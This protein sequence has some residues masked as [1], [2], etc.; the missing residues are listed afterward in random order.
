MKKFYPTILLALLCLTTK[1]QSPNWAWAQGVGNTDS[2]YGVSIVNDALGNLYVTGYFASSSILFGS[3]LLTNSGSSDI[4]IAKYD[5]LGN[6]LWAKSAGGS[7]TEYAE[8]VATD[9]FGNVYVSGNFDSPTINFGANTLTN[10]GNTDMFI[11][12]YDD[13][14]NV[15]WA[16]RGGGTGN[17][18]ARCTSTDAFGNV[19]VTGNFASPSI[20]FGT[21]TL[22]NSN[23]P[24]GDIYL[25][26][27]DA[28]GNLVWAKREG[29]VGDENVMSAA[30]DAFGNVYI[31]GCYI[32]STIT[33]G[34]TSLINT[35][36]GDVFLVKYDSSGNAL[37][38]KGFGG[39]TGIEIANAVAIDPLGNV[40]VT[41]YY[42]STNF[43]IDTITLLNSGNRDIF[44]VKFDAAGN[45]VWI[46]GVGNTG[47]EQASSINVDTDG[48]VYITG[49]YVSPSIS[50]GSTTIVNQG[51][52]DIFLLKYDTNGNIIWSEGIGG[53]DNETGTDIAADV[54][55]NIYITGWYSSPS[56][57]FGSIVL[58][59]AGLGD[60]FIA[61]VDASLTDDK[62]QNANLEF[63]FYPNPSTGIYCFNDN[64]N[65]QSIEVFNMMGELILSQGN[66]KQ[67]N[68]QAFPKGIY[69]ARINGTF[70][71]RL[72][73]E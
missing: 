2:D 29:Q 28:Q 72:V 44:V 8:S 5:A 42:E 59:N 53:F 27:Y 30:V 20:I 71:A 23:S 54:Y 50:I 45:F 32:S 46:H 36:G 56:I 25:V 6:L 69:V 41:G 16:K 63:K 19:Y 64:R 40:C 33:F 13:Q 11:V 51:L 14:G 49:L 38:A 37:W 61:K 26:K 55:G 4:F 22:S 62:E 65:I 31:T 58:N 24:L 3:T 43:M 34:A 12:K 9:S 10:Q 1:A 39:S 21:T 47:L 7:G 48:N 52:W 35:G 73:K 57:T 70:V 60:I 67:I 15:L 18:S 66:A 17:E 68:L